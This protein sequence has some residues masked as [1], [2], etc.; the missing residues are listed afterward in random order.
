MLIMLPLWVFNQIV[1]RIHFISGFLSYFQAL[2][3]FFTALRFYYVF[4][5]FSSHIQ[6]LFSA[7]CWLPSILSFF[8]TTS[9]KAFNYFF[10]AQLKIPKL[11]LKS[12]NISDPEFQASHHTFFSFQ[13][14]IP[15]S[16]D[17]KE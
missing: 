17:D 3:P 14:K 10:G 15:R 1:S 13:L 9:L 16:A 8:L 11:K 2:N 7:F 5:Q 12:S 6:R 4:N